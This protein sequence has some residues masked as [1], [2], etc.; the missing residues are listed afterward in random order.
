MGNRRIR[1]VI[2]AAFISM[3]GAVAM[4]N[5]IQIINKTS[6]DIHEV[7]VSDTEVNDWEED[8]LGD[9]VLESGDAATVTIEGNH[10]G[11]DLKAVDGDG[12]SVVWTN[13]N[14]TGATK[15]SLYADGTAVLE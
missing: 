14:L 5:D 10:E 12:N 7:Y 9:E 2:L 11:W 6:F 15:I 8:I 4:A 3:F 1:M 13:L